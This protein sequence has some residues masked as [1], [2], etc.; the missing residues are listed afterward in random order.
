[1]PTEPPSGSP[2]RRGGAPEDAATS[3]QV[4]ARVWLPSVTLTAPVAATRAQNA[5]SGSPPRGQA[6][7]VP[8]GRMLHCTT[9]HHTNHCR[10]VQRLTATRASARSASSART[11]SLRSPRS[12][13]C[14]VRLV[15]SIRFGPRN[16]LTTARFCRWE[17]GT[18]ALL[19]PAVRCGEESAAG[20]GNRHAVNATAVRR[21]PLDAQ[22]ASPRA[23][24]CGLKR[25]P[26][27]S[28]H[29]PGWP[30]PFA[31]RA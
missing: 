26:P 11:R 15:S 27:A 1:M 22:P 9:P 12:S 3:P 14:S 24:C 23:A 25:L 30:A 17:V 7:A 8:P 20:G 18:A 29:P 19:V 13:C 16:R 28:I 6:L 31:G 5:L 2:A 21:A 10:P 4:A